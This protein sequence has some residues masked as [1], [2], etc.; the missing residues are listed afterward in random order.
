MA[1]VRSK[2]VSPRKRKSPTPSP[3]NAERPLKIGEAAKTLGVEAYVLRF[4]ETQFPFLRPKH[5]QSRHRFYGQSDIETL[6]LIKRLLHTEGYTIAG[7]R[8]HIREVGLERL[9]SGMDSPVERK[10][11]GISPQPAVPVELQRALIE[12]REDLRSLHR[13]LER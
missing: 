9:R 12:I 10:A 13:M 8:K 2:K 5:S 6:R 3:E 7:A 11:N 4:W 1:R